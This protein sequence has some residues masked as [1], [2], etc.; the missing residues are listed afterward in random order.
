MGIL[1]Y[2]RTFVTSLVPMIWGIM[3]HCRRLHIDLTRAFALAPPIQIQPQ[4]ENSD[5]AL[6]MGRCE[7]QEKDM[8]RIDFVRRHFVIRR[9]ERVEKRILLNRGAL[10]AGV[11][12]CIYRR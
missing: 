5:L 10:H 2:L 9:E 8:R 7:E 3:Y 11:Y 12:L 6:S 4:N 1:F